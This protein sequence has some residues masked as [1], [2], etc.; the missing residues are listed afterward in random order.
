MPYFTAYV[1][2]MVGAMAHL[3]K[4]APSIPMP[5]HSYLPLVKR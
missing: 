5:F 3:G 1:K 2:A 4:V